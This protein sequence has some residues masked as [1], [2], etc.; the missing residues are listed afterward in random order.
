MEKL[1]NELFRDYL[2]KKSGLTDVEWQQI[3]PE[4]KCREVKK[5]EV[6]VEPGVSFPYFFFVEKGLLRFYSLDKDGKEHI[7]QFAPENWFVGDRNGAYCGTPTEFW[8]D[9]LEDSTVIVL[10]KYFIEKIES[11]SPS[12]RKA[13]EGLLQNHIRLLQQRINMLL[14]A[15][16]EQRY[17]S[18][19]QLYPNLTLRVP[20]W[21]IASYLGIT[22]ESLSRV[23]RKL[24]EQYK[25]KKN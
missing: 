22:P 6:L 23:R 3:L 19:I 10:D 9:V 17:L 7:V 1:Q 8:I 4:L 13:N 14:S 25:R 18:F 5:G 12:F 21:M 20:Q 16:A 24:A 11:I 2:V 15:T